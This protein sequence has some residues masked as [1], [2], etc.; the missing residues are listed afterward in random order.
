MQK[1]FNKTIIW[2]I[3]QLSDVGGGEK[4][5]LEGAKYYRSIG[6]KVKIITW[7]F[8]DRVLFD[9]RYENLDIISFEENLVDRK[10]IFRRS[11]SRFK[12]LLK[13]R[14]ILISE[15][16]LLVITQGE[17]DVAILYIATIFTNIKYTFL[18]FGQTYQYPHDLGKYSLIFRRHLN[19]IIESQQGYR[20]TISKNKPSVSFINNVTNEIIC[21][22]RYFAVRKAVQRFSFS[23]YVQW[24]TQ[25]LF[26]CNT[27]ILKGAYSNNIFTEIK[28][29][30]FDFY[31]R[32]NIP[33][34]KKIVMSF[35]RLDAKKRIDIIIQS[36]TF[37]PQNYVLCICGKGKDFDRLQLLTKYLELETRVH[38]L[39]FIPEH[40]S[41]DTKRACDIFVSMDIGDFDIS[42]FEA[43]ALGKKIILPT[44][45]DLDYNLTALKNIS[46][47][48]VDPETLANKIM[49]IIDIPA[50]FQ[51]D[52]LKYYTWENY[53]DTILIKSLSIEKT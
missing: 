31:Q 21:L 52:I 10:N 23:R 29:I 28:N 30:H 43:L 5:L 45:F 53:F 34:D 48:S 40:E 25:K 19:E 47:I 14:K 12:S 1:T 33:S 51:E 17:Y 32:H 7:N 36:I 3:N 39:G 15:N 35:S 24:E 4:L 2:I 27:I 13:L 37:L 42:P 44:E 8:N 22:I 11:Y 26:R 16:P 46:M 9:G 49:E 41:N 6:Y 38:F 20:E 18:I 50:V